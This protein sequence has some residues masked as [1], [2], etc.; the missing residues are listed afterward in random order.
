MVLGAPAHRAPSARALPADALSE[1]LVGAPRLTIRRTEHQA[2][3][4]GNPDRRPQRIA[5]LERS[6]RGDLV[7]PYHPAYEAVRRGWS[8][9]STA[10]R[11]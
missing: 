3:V 2:A 8:G 5:P 11:R 6:F 9:S 4:Y 7:D 1:L 10:G